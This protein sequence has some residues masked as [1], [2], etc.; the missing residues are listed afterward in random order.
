MRPTRLP[1]TGDGLRQEPVDAGAD[2]RTGRAGSR[3]RPAARDAPGCSPWMSAIACGTSAEDRRAGSP[4]RP[5][6]SPGSATTSVLLRTPTTCRERYAAGKP[7]EVSARIFSAS[8]GTS[9]SIDLA[10]ALGRAVARRDARAA[11]QQDQV[12]LARVGA[13]ADGARDL[14]R[15]VRAGPRATTTRC[16]IPDCRSASSQAGP[17]LVLARAG[18]DAVGDRQDRDADHACIMDRAPPTSGSGPSARPSSRAARS[19]GSRSPR[20]SALA[21]S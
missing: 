11:R 19:R 13:H 5:W 15:L 20:S 14:L 7:R 6:A 2:R 16:S 9:K 21:M 3:A 12:G 17:P 10:H 18:G 8:P 1:A 4:P